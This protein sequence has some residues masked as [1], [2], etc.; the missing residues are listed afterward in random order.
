METFSRV[1]GDSQENNFL[2]VTDGKRS[3]KPQRVVSWLKFENHFRF[4][5][6]DTVIKINYE[7]WTFNSQFM[8][9]KMFF[10]VV[11]SLR[12]KFLYYS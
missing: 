7:M 4:H 2:P 8:K 1:S 12:I 10:V 9:V 6:D 11:N 5:V 3:V